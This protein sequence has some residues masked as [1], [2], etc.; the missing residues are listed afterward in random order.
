[1]CT[2]ENLIFYS[3]QLSQVAVGEEK[4]QSSILGQ[5]SLKWQEWIFLTADNCPYAGAP[6]DEQ[7]EGRAQPRC[8]F[9]AAVSQDI[10]SLVFD[11]L[12]RSR[13]S[14]SLLQAHSFGNRICDPLWNPQSNC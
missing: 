1:M 13:I 8:F 2:M 6:Q 9:V 7:M 10:L 14:C 12:G 3:S 5:F 4:R 11:W